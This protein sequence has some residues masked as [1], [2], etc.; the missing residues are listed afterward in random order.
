MSR[1]A[2]RK[3]AFI[4]L[5]QKEFHDEDELQEQV[6]LYFEGC[7]PISEENLEFI[8]RETL[9]VSK[10]LETIDGLI[11]KNLT[12]WEIDRINKI[13]LAIIRLAVY[14]M[15]YEN[16][17]PAGVSIYEAVELAKQYG[18]D[19]SYQ[20][21]NGILGKIFALLEDENNG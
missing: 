3:H 6:R 13:D 8:T 17:I 14:E 2:A 9:G 4:L 19:E 15:L 11:V 5:F 20:F 1:R 21:V 10:N 16:K 7:G 18:T 12:G